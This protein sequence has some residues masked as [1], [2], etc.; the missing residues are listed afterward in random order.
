MTLLDFDKGSL[1]VGTSDACDTVPHGNLDDTERAVNSSM[2]KLARR[3]GLA[4]HE[5][6]VDGNAVLLGF[7]ADVEAHL[8]RHGIGRVLDTA[9]VFPPEAYSV[10]SART[11]KAG[12]NKGKRRMEMC[13]PHC[14]AKDLGGKEKK[15]ACTCA[16]TREL[17]P[18]VPRNLSIYWRLLR[19]ELLLLLKVKEDG[20]RKDQ[21]GRLYD[22]D[23]A[24]TGLSSD[25]FSTLAKN[26]GDRIQ[27]D[28]R[29]GVAT[30]FMMEV[31]VPKVAST[32]AARPHS[33]WWDGAGLTA[34]FHRL[35]VNMRHAGAVWVLLNNKCKK[36]TKELKKAETELK[37]KEL[38]N[39]L[40]E[41]K[42]ARRGVVQEMFTRTVKNLL[43][44]DLRG[45]MEMGAGVYEI[46]QVRGVWFYSSSSMKGEGGVCLCAFMCSC[47]R[48][49]LMLRFLRVL[50]VVGVQR[51]P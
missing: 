32:L 28:A 20:L 14:P 15:K 40:G 21:G 45:A 6:N 16:P 48:V 34:I 47:M 1:K 19:P 13:F 18:S 10:T 49:P 41:H 35:G 7:G 8:D 33:K 43:R 42:S 29:I 25:G 51:V 44:R 24:A 30:T 46:G 27:H 23:L 37:K 9:R 22:D 11:F 39:E 2:N 31:Q 5:V 38:E 26:G 17:L 12:K 3:I 50:I 36:L 4:V